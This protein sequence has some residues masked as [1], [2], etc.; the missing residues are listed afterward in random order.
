MSDEY[1][2]L[3]LEVLHMT[4]DAMYVSD[5]DMQDWIPRSQVK[6]GADLGFDIIGE[7]Q[8]F[9]IAEWVAKQAGFI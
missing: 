2:E 7:T 6:D 1:I 3:D 5:G 9:E 4:A 8:T